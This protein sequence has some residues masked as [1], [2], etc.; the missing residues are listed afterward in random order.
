[1]KRPH[2]ACFLLLL[3]ASHLAPVSARDAPADED[4][5]K[6]PLTPLAI[7]NVW[8]YENADDGVTVTETIAGVVYFDDQPWYLVR[9][10]ERPSDGA[11]DAQPAFVWESWLAH[12]DGAD[13]LALT[14]L[15]PDTGT[16]RLSEPSADFRYP[17][18]KGD[19]YRPVEKDASRTVHVVGVDVPIKTKAGDFK[20]IAYRE[21]HADEADVTITTYLAPGVGVVR[22]AT[23][24][25]G[26]VS[27]ADLIK[28]TRA[29]R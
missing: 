11:D 22:I 25:D 7:G 14:E 1:M 17:V 5:P 2:L 19:T 16:L 3:V 20:C 27:H 4:Q 15:D 21:D 26:E 13:T 29:Q 18:A 24:I 23:E 28:F 8:V 9:S 10:A 12:V 6:A